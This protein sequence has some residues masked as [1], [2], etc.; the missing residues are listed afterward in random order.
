MNINRIL[1]VIML[2]APVYREIADDQQ[3]TREAATVFVVVTLI[4]GFFNGIVKSSNG[5]NFLSIGGAIGGAIG[6]LIIGLIG[7]VFT[8]WV[9]AFVAKQLDGKTS[10][11]EML[12]VTGYVSVFS[13]VNVLNIFKLIPLLG[14]LTTLIAIAVWI[15]SLVGYV[16]GVR[17]A[18]EFTTGKAIIAAIVAVIVNFVI[19]FVIGGIII[20]AVVALFAFAGG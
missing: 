12:R 17:E 13:L 1:G 14:C 7:W 8:S 15:L 9:L 18:A 10:T 4:S 16:I 11:S 6:G 19:V 5:V 3:A 20:A 2:R